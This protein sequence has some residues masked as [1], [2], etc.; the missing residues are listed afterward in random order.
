MKFLKKYWH[1]IAAGFLGILLFLLIF[2][3]EPLRYSGIGWTQHGFGGSDITQ[4]QIGWMFYRN[5]PWTFPLCK[6]LFLGYPEGTPISY[7]DSIPLAALFFK[8]LSPLLPKNFQYFGLYTCLCFMLQSIFSAALVFLLTQNRPY[9]LTGSMIFVTASC[10]LERCFRHTAL[11]SHWLLLAALLLYLV[12]KRQ[13]QKNYYILIGLLFCTSLGIH[14]YL[15]AM[16]FAVLT[17]SE[18]EILLAKPGQRKQTVWF[19][20][21]IVLSLAF[22]YILGIFGTEVSPAS[23]YGMYSLNLNALFNPYS[24]H[25]RIWSGFLQNREQFPAQGDGMY[26]IGLPLLILIAISLFNQILLHDRSFLSVHRK[27][28]GLVILLTAFTIIAVSNVITFDRQILRVITLPDVITD[29][30]NVFRSSARFFF[31]PYYCLI[32]ATLVWLYRIM[33]NRQSLAIICGLVTAVLQ[34]TEIRPGLQDLHRFF[35]TRYDYIGL[36]ED[37]TKLAERY[38]TARTFDCLTNQSLAFWLA[39]NNFRT[40]MMISAPVHMDAYWQRTETERERLRDALAAGTETLSNDTIYI[41]STETGTNRSFSSESEL[42]SYI[43]SV[44]KA[45][46]GKADLLYLT[47]WVRDYWVLCPKP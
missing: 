4:H 20:V 21:C 45:Y 32:L 8:L 3:I 24:A 5:S 37:W 39:K 18:V 36:S 12:R 2:G 46:T 10:F 41:I 11:S 19:P 23:G 47:D 29:G 43:D 22:G 38:D 25:H 7:T 31:L 40:D 28:A 42:E 16:V 44:K 1:L 9:S 14:P 6:A 35:E 34:I 26:Y 27:Y 30:L 15:F 13:S 17:L 33:K